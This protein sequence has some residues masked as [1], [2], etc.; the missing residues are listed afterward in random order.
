LIFFPENVNV[1]IDSGCQIIAVEAYLRR[2]EAGSSAN[3]R[4]ARTT[5]LP[6]VPMGLREADGPAVTASGAT[7]DAGLPNTT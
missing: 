2:A 7:G 4:G 1:Q 5:R 6:L 3:E